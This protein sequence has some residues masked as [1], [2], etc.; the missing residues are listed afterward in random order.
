MSLD[1][2]PK[3]YLIKQCRNKLNSACAIKP[4]P[5]EE[6]GAHISFKESLVNQLQ[7]LVSILVVFCILFM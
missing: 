7:Q 3:S 4:T 5:G 2:M 1:G 6:P